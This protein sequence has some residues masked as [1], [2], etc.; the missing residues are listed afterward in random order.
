MKTPS[1]KQ[2]RG[3]TGCGYRGIWVVA[4]PKI[5]EA[6]RWQKLLKGVAKLY[7]DGATCDID[8]QKKTI[9]IRR[10]NFKATINYSGYPE[11][12]SEWMLQLSRHYEDL[13]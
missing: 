9:Y 13:L 1:L 8:E 3:H 10:E 11:F 4:G 5:T 7:G 6:Q 2:I 12:I